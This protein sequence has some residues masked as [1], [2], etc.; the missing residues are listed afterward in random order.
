MRTSTRIIE[1]SA[2]DLRKLDEEHAEICRRYTGLEETI[3][4]GRGLPR[5]LEAANS[6]VQMMLLHFTHEEQ[7]LERLS[8]SS[9][10]RQRDANIE[11]TAQL[12]DIEVGLEHSRVASVF[13]SLL[14][15]RVW[16]KEH[17]R[18][19]SEEFKCE[20]LIEAGRPFL[21]SPQHSGN[22]PLRPA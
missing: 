14:L 8:L 18:L 15:G 17:M 2:F 3:L 7:F 10:Q 5:I 6:L 4:R 22:H 19:E 21:V 13:Q 12:F 1:P 9:F 11:I 16:I 20:D